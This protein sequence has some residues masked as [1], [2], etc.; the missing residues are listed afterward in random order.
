[1]WLSLPRALNLAGGLGHLW[2]QVRLAWRLLFD[3][4]VPVLHK[5]I[6]PA[7]VLYVVWPLDF[8]PDFLPFL[9]QVD[10]L[11]AVVLATMLF[12][13]LAPARLVAEHRADLAG[14]RRPPAAERDG[15]V[16]DGDYRV[17]DDEGR[18]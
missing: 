4:R 15:S 6:V 16:I 18:R 5:L 13:R 14:R 10:D 2:L 7:T 12:V 11:S 1:M 8:L 9:G 17:L 3:V